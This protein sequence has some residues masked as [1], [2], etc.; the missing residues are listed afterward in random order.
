MSLTTLIKRPFGEVSKKQWRRHTEQIIGSRNLAHT[1]YLGYVR[2]L[3]DFNITSDKWK[4]IDV[5]YYL[6]DDYHPFRKRQ[7]LEEPHK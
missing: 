5:D 2:Q 7:S 4:D 6:E 3:A 1:P